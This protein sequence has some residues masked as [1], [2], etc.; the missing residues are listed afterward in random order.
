MSF[1]FDF[2]PR[3]FVNISKNFG[4]NVKFKVVSDLEQQGMLFVE[5]GNHGEYRPLPDEFV[6]NGIPFVRPPNL[7]DGR[8]DLNACQ[9]IND[10]AFR[11]V[12]KGIGRGGDVV[13]THNATIGRVAKTRDS[14]PT[15]V[16]NPQTT[17]WRALDR[18]VID[19]YYLY[20]FMRSSGFQEQLE[21]HK[22]RNATF[23]YVS[24][25]KQRSLVVPILDI[26]IQRKIGSY[27]S[28]IDEKIF[29]NTQTNQTLEEMAQAI[30]KSWFVDFDPVKVKMNGEQPEGMDAATASLFPE[31][32]VESEL[33][34]IPEG[35]KV[36]SLAKIAKLDTTSVNP[37]K[38]PEI[39][40]EHFSIPAFDAGCYPS[41]D[42]GES[43]KS[44]KY[45]V[46]DNSVLVS[47]LNPRFQ[48]IWLP[49]PTM[50]E[51]AICSTEFMQF[52]PNC[53]AFKAYLYNLVKSTPF[54][55]EL[56]NTVTGTTGSRQRAQP[57]QVA[58]AQVV[59]PS[60]KLME[61]YCQKVDAMLSLS[62]QNIRQNIELAKLRD[63]LLPKLLS[64]EIELANTEDMA[65]VS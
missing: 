34:L 42:T 52:V 4:D 33:G 35:W 23:D 11:R 62:Q 10:V 59:I 46:K 39:I 6:E 36:D 26:D 3:M 54:Q 48:R 49:L 37:A 7:I 21:A 27:L 14:D 44:G 50:S 43:I 64:G 8:I 47:K 31:K 15:F 40:W 25:T 38:E 45:A 60:S 2:L 20:Y 16:T 53:S 55:N 41:F 22:G 57:K 29:L 51:K 63:T 58:K 28:C 24:L 5:D 17:V 12:R 18:D 65:E 30:F 13:L 19:P 61:I 1:N 9:K 56:L 32:L